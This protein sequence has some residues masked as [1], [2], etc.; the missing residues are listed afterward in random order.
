MS[1]TTSCFRMGPLK[2]WMFCKMERDVKMTKC[3]LQVGD[4]DVGMARWRLESRERCWG[5]GEAKGEGTAAG[6]E[7]A[8]PGRGCQT[9]GGCRWRGKDGDVE[10]LKWRWQGGRNH[11]KMCEEWRHQGSVKMHVL[12]IRA[13]HYIN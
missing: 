1:G 2:S 6:V 5:Q 13:G 3:R 7:E 10:I 11:R 9:G 4:G 8:G 12:A